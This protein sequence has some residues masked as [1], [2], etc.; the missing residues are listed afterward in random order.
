MCVVQGVCARVKKRGLFYLK[1]REPVS[2]GVGVLK[3]H[4]MTINK[5]RG[6]GGMIYAGI[7]CGWFCC[8]GFIIVGC[9]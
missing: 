1:T 9:M 6:G 5:K 3:L 4:D 7:H 2:M 8:I